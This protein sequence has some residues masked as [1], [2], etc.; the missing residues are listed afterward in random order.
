MLMCHRKECVQTHCISDAMCRMLLVLPRAKLLKLYSQ[1]RERGL[2][3]CEHN[4]CNPQ[5]I[6][7]LIHFYPSTLFEPAGVFRH[8]A[9][10]AP[11]TGLTN[12]KGD[13]LTILQSVKIRGSIP[14]TKNYILRNICIGSGHQPASSSAVIVGSVKNER[15]YTSTLPTQSCVA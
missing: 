8:M 11:L 10:T 12:G 3:R 7:P 9:S 13:I 1:K 14:D 5:H 2:S 6:T 4:S 15:S